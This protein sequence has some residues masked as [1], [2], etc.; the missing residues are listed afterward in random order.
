MVASGLVMA[1]RRKERAE[2]ALKTGL[3]SEERESNFVQNTT[4]GVGTI[5]NSAWPLNNL[6]VLCFITS[7]PVFGLLAW[8]VL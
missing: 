7:H 6:M 4:C 5:F 2:N 3:V 8:W 1:S